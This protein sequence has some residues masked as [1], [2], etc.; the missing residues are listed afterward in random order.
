MRALW[1]KLHRWITLVFAIPLLVVIATGLVLSFEP[2][3]Q[4]TSPGVKLGKAEMLALLARHDP[5]GKATGLSLR[6]YGGTLTIAG[7]GAEGE[8][9]IDL[10]SGQLNEEE[11]FGLSDV[12]RTARGLHE[13]LLL[14][15]EWLVIASTFAMLVLGALG[16]LMGW[17]R[18]RNSFGGWH[19]GAAWVA[20]PLVILS[21]LTGLAIAYGF[22]F[23]PASQGARGERMALREAVEKLADSAVMQGRDFANVTS[24][25][26]RGGRMVARVFVDGGLTNVAI[27]RT[28]AEIQLRNWPRAVHEGNWSVLG[29]WLNILVSVVFLGLWG[30]GLYIWARRKLRRRQPRVTRGA[31][32]A[33]E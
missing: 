25:R 29:A 4:Q 10:A 13:A 12:F 7:V 16:L 15:M 24:L 22:T 32:A 19:Q 33:A 23:L 3:A 26:V 11:G 21:P 2:L 17:P 31:A 1:L 14:N 9:D 30:T 20:L 8:I 5:E 6:S 18:W 27:T 28:G